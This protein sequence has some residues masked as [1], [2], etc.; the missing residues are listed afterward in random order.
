M[1]FKRKSQNES[2]EVETGKVISDLI[3][4]TQATIQFDPK[5]HILTAN[6][7]FLAAFGY[8]LEEIRGQHHTMFVDADHAKNTDYTAFWNRLLAGD[9]IT[10]QFPRVAKDGSIIWIQA[11][12][13]P[14]L[15]SENNVVRVIQVASEVTARRRGLAAISE[16]LAALQQGDLAYRV[17][18]SEIPD[19]GDLGR[20]FN[21]S[22]KQLEAT[23]SNAKAVCTGVGRTATDI[24]QAAG[25]L[26]RRT[27]NQATT[28]EE[29]AAAL[30]ELTTTV[31]S[32]A[33]GAKKVEDIVAE[34]QQ[35][36]KHSG[37]V[38][39]E[40]ITAMSKIEGSSDEIAK[41]TTVIDDIAFQTNLLALNAGVEAARAGE[42]GRG[43]A[44][45]AS[46]VRGLA[47]RSA[48][49]AGEIKNLIT[50][51]QHH[52]GSGVDLVGKTGEELEQIIKSVGTISVHI[53]D[54]ARGAAEQSAA[55]GEINTGMVQLDEV[56]QKNAAMVEETSAV[57]QTLS[58]DA[59]QLTQQLGAFR[60]KGDGAGIAA[61]GGNVIRMSAATARGKQP[62]S[63]Q[64]PVSV[65]APSGQS[66]GS[67]W[68]DF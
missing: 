34:A 6:N 7:N 38:V 20:S 55:L 8:R 44:V 64:A 60:T 51:S 48:D 36:A 47:Q 13:A 59:G 11:T 16:G 54:I 22:V 37:V 58:N 41:I 27:E 26:S 63:A 33:N 28:L 17:A 10:D 49:A 42:A 29:T 30:D 18:L 19:I 39:S 25:D 12:Y 3:D 67:G 2:S 66:D 52:V 50:Q 46:E 5:G 45:V 23:V 15:D 14:V 21:Q 9:D 62:R 24:S 43:F 1:F 32:S 4:R 61:A 53:G 68:E 31:K 57:S 35:V 56:T 65:G 40:A